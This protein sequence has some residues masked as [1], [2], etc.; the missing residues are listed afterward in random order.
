VA[1]NFAERLKI[2]KQLREAL[3]ALDKAKA[4]GERLK[5]V[6]EVRRLEALLTG[7]EAQT[8]TPP[9]ET[10]VEPEGKAEAEN[11]DIAVIRSI[12]DGKHPDMEKP[13]IADVLN[14]LITKYEN[15]GDEAILDLV[16]QAIEAVETR[17]LDLTDEFDE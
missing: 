14:G 12:I 7:G 11:P 5:L 9:A 8:A 15:S 17:V 16:D 6:A 2:A 13:E 10:K 3:D 4:F 1:L